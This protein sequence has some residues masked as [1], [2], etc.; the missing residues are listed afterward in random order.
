MAV[1]DLYL[2]IFLAQYGEKDFPT[3]HSD[4]KKNIDIYMQEYVVVV[5]TRKRGVEK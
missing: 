2:Y 5:T 3:V 1:L 4:L